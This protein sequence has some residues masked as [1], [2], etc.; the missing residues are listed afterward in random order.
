MFNPDPDDVNETLI[1]VLQSKTESAKVNS[2]DKIRSR[3]TIYMLMYV[4]VKNFILIRL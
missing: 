1:D 2:C 3:F 4:E